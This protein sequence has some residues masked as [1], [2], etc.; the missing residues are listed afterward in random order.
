MPLPDSRD[1]VET[2]GV[3]AGSCSCIRPRHC[4]KPDFDLVGELRGGWN[5]QRLLNAVLKSYHVWSAR[6]C[7]ILVLD[8]AD[9][10][11]IQRLNFPAAGP[12]RACRHAEGAWWS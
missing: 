5:A 7:P 4:S 3:A 11:L 1:E 2:H 6:K 10:R 12:P 9:G 8:P